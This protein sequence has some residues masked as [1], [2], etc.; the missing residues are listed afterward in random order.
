[1]KLNS[2]HSRTHYS[3]GES[4]GT[5]KELIE[6]AKKKGLGTVAITDHGTM[7][8]I[9]DAYYEGKKQEYPVVLGLETSVF[10]SDP[11]STYRIVLLAQNQKGYSNLSKITSEGNEIKRIYNKHC[12]PTS[13]ITEH[14]EG[15]IAIL[16][17]F[18]NIIGSELM[19]GMGH[20]TF[21][22]IV[23]HIDRK[24]NN[25]E[26][27][28]S[29]S[30]E[31]LIVTC[32]SYMPSESMKELQDIMIQNTAFA[33]IE[34]FRESK[35]LMSLQELINKCVV[36][37]PY[38]TQ[39]ILLSGLKNAEMLGDHCKTI[40]LIFK[41]QIVDFP[42]KLHPLNVG[43]KLSKE[44]LVIKIIRENARFDMSDPVYARRLAYEMTTITKN[45][46]VNLTDYFLVIEDLIRWC[47]EV[48]I[49]VGPGRGSGAGSLVNYGL[50]ITRL[51]PIKYGLLFERFISTGRI[52]A[53][54]LPD[55]DIDFSDPKRV[56]EYLRERYG[57]ERVVPIGTMQTLK[58]ASAFKDA[59]RY[60]YPNEP[61]VIFNSITKN[62]PTKKEGEKELDYYERAK[63]D[64]DFVAREVSRFPLVDAA[65]K[66]LLGYNRQPSIH[67][68]GVAITNDPIREVAP[69]R[70]NKDREVLDYDG[71][72][73][74]KAGI[75]KYDAL[76]LKTMSF[77]AES[78]KLA[79]IDID[80]IPLDDQRTYQEFSKARTTGVF[81]FGSAIV[82]LGLKDVNSI[83]GLDDV[84]M[85]TSLYRPGP[86]GSGQHTEF[87]D[88]K[89]GKKRATPL[90]PLI[91]HVT[92]DTQHIM[93]YQEQVMLASQILG[94]F[95]LAEA[96]D[97]RKAMGKKKKDLIDAYGE[98]FIQ[99]FL[100]NNY[101]T[102][103]EAS[104]IWHKMETFAGY[105][106]NKSHAMSYALIG[107]YCMY[108]K[109]HYP[110][111]WWCGVL[112]HEDKPEKVR[113]YYRSAKGV[114]NLPDINNSYGQYCIADGKVQM[115]FQAVKWVGQTAS[116]DIYSHRP[117]HSFDNFLS[118]VNT[119]VVNKRVVEN[120]IFSSAFSSIE[121]RTEIELIDKYYD[122]R[123]GK[124]PEN[125]CNLTFSNV[126]ERRADALDFLEKDVTEIY[127]HL[128]EDQELTSTRSLKA[129]ASDECVTVGGEIGVIRKMKT[130]KDES[131]IIFQLEND[132][133]IAECV[134]WPREFR[135]L[136]SKVKAKEIIKV[137]GVTKFGFGKTQVI[138]NKIETFEDMTRSHNERTA[139]RA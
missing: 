53:G 42:H 21:F 66:R 101:G 32:D 103:A 9:I 60:Y 132:G 68:C 119:S 34:S 43:G 58:A 121:G 2:L 90:H 102:K 54:T 82:Q 69:T 8:G 71:D 48:G 129:M 35:F 55:I 112:T 7:S 124:R 25:L 41:D 39:D 64:S 16:C 40:D 80:S 94:G 3:C 30:K 52:E 91:E 11:M 22:E 46:R 95:S 98:R 20:R 115:P 74:E 117:Y 89:N 50:K 93:I 24:E 111:Q 96:D 120:L 45:K 127:P 133:V 77:L 139:R 86:M 19:S 15:L 88:R 23:P 31:K 116:E 114:I 137:H 81:Q 67:P 47:K 118:K 110:L 44:E 28:R 27:I 92:Q 12:V 85:F 84:T 17:D 126:L 113:E 59:F 36:E 26:T 49:A 134:M 14:S 107:Y 105:G 83:D 104:D 100:D 29:I 99:N 106:F 122:F 37:H 72:S 63:E 75:I 73:A 108:M 125:M 138:V 76:G 56:K 1:M 79:K 57:S 130:G 6:T 13:F 38:L 4:V 65:V 61:F 33:D 18:N 62:F 51:D 97:I 131:F 123:G 10:Y 87:I 70:Y 78:T 109:V 136:S 135:A 5:V 128:F